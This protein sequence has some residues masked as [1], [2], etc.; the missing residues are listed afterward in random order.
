ME[1]A[2]IIR[3][4]IRIVACALEDPSID[5]DRL[6]TKSQPDCLSKYVVDVF[7][8]TWGKS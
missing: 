2:D 3:I 6:D 7:E 4:I 5:L 8:C 1:Y